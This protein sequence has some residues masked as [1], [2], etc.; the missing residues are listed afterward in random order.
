MNFEDIKRIPFKEKSVLVTE[1]CLMYR[2]TERH[3]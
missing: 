1:V 2:K 3:K